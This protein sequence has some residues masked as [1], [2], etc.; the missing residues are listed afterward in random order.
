MEG[1][2][3]ED[4]EVGEG[5]DE[6]ALSAAVEVRARD[7]GGVEG[8]WG[9]EGWVAVIGIRVVVWRLEEED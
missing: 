4:G 6:V 3:A 2:E 8:R 9:D 7:A 1:E 5:S